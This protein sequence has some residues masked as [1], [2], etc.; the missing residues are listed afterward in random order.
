MQI[1]ISPLKITLT[2]TLNT[3]QAKQTSPIGIHLA[4]QHENIQFIP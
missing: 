1:A 2:A 3:K 4:I